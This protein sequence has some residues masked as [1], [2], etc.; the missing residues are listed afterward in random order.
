MAV[1][2]S[3]GAGRRS[4]LKTAALGTAAAAASQTAR[5]AVSKPGTPLRIGVMGVTDS[6]ISYSWSDIMEGTMPGNNPRA[7]SFGTSLLN[8]D[9]TQV[10][11]KD[12]AAAQKYAERLGAT[13]VKNYDDMVGKVDGVI[14]GGMNEVPWYPQLAEPYLKAG[15]PLYLSRPFA[16]NMKA[17]DRIIEMAKATNTPILATAKYEHYNEI[18]A[19]RSKIGDIAV[20]NMVHATGNSR[21]F[22]MHFHIMFMMLQIL[23]MDVEEVSL[24]TDGLARNKYSQVTLLY[25]GNEKQP[26]FLCTIN[27]IGNDK[28]QFTV[29]VFGDKYNVETNMIRSP[30]W[31][32]SLLFRYAPQVIEMQ[33]TFEGNLFEPYE[34]IRK[35]TAVWLAAYYSHAE[36]GG[37]PVKVSEVPYDWEGPLLTPNWLD[38]AMFR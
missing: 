17:I 24:V 29:T 31:R 2:D 7:G 28:D 25:P 27:G 3:H 5:A 26:P 13:A 10:W 11:D 9:I 1:S 19:L 4:F 35:K 18:P 6:F 8:M 12:F 14:F 30:N 34:N 16:Y 36:R 23:G 20:V 37:A 33:R 15:T 21:D 32:D 38:P 22:P